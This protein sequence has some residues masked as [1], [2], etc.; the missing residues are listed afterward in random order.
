MSYQRWTE[1]DAYV[2]G[3]DEGFHCVACEHFKTYRQIIEHLKTKHDNS[4][5]AI[6][7]LEAEAKLAGLDNN[8]QQLEK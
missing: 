3:D 5:L 8:W 7:K 2:I 4:H 1:G 6:D